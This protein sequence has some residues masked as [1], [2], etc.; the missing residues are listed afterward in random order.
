M[1]NNKIFLFILIILVITYLYLSFSGSK[2][3]F[4]S[5]SNSLLHDDQ[6]YGVK[7]NNDIF[8]NFY[9]FL[10]DEIHDDDATRK[11]I[12]KTIMKY[13]NTSN[14]LVLDVS[15]K[16]GH[17]TELLTNSVDIKCI[18]ANH[19]MNVMHK[20]KYPQHDIITG[21]I[22]DPDAILPNTFTHVCVNELEIYNHRNIDYIF[23]NLNNWLIHDGV[24]FMLVFKNM[25]EAKKY[26][27]NNKSLM[28]G[29]F[30]YSSNLVQKSRNQ[31]A[32]TENIHSRF[33]KERKNIVD[34][35]FHSN[36]RLK[37]VAETNG[38][39]YNGKESI[40]NKLELLIFKKVH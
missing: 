9:T 1:H 10:Y 25:I 19:K 13:S 39:H 36:D 27:E 18:D 22:S 34:K 4:S 16:C 33:N 37:Y 26:Y 23:M 38:F 24:L 21:E 6:N 2:E 29:N 5:D 17:L 20:K 14:N 15:S 30:I 11:Q 32:L 3:G 12:A 8:D 28:N 40:N 35:Y 7:M 31:Y